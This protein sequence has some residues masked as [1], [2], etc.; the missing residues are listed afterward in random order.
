MVLLYQH[1]PSLW[2]PRI[3]ISVANLVPV[4]GIELLLDAFERL[5]ANYPDWKLLIVG[6]DTTEYGAELKR[7]LLEKPSIREKVIFT[8]RQK[9]IRKFLD[10]SEIYVQPTLKKGR[11]EGAP[12]A[13]LE[14]M[15]NGKIVVGSDIQGIKDQ[16]EQFS[17]NQFK[18]GDVTE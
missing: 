18:A 10:I 12:F 5:T 17:N 8:W 7:K 13:I 16:L 3:I 11:M 14:A 2:K 6:N 15:A 9:N 1:K 4:K